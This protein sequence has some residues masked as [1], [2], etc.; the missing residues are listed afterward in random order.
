MTV[1]ALVTALAGMGID[2]KKTWVT[3]ARLGGA[4]RGDY[5]T[6]GMTVAL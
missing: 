6:R 5:F 4:W 3:K 1:R 2:R